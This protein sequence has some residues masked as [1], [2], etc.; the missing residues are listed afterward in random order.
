MNFEQIKEKFEKLGC[1]VIKF[2]AKEISK[3]FEKD[4]GQEI[5]QEMFGI[6]YKM[7][8]KNIIQINYLKLIFLSYQ[9]KHNNIYRLKEF[10]LGV[11]HMRTLVTKE[12]RIE[13]ITLDNIKNGEV[14]LMQ[15]NEIYDK[16]GFVFIADSGKF[17]GI[18][19]ERRH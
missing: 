15:L 19:K 7:S 4:F 3:D 5:L 8:N 16:M 12:K 6:D 1:E 11:I 14:T 18:R 2:P 13:E 17:T 10:I 9:Y